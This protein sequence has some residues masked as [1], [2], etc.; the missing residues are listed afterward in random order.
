[1]SKEAC[2]RILK[3][4]GISGFVLHYGAR[5]LTKTEKQVIGRFTARFCKV[6]QNRLVF[7]NRENLDYTDNPRAFFDYLVKEGYNEKYEIIWLVSDLKKF[8]KLKYKNVKFV[9]AENKY[10]WN[11]CSAYYYTS[12]ARYFFFSHNTQDLLDYGCPGRTIINLWHGCGYKGPERG[13]TENSGKKA[14]TGFD[15]GLVPGPVFVET[16]SVAWN[17]EKEKIWPIGYPR[18]DWML[19]P[20]ITKEKMIQRLFGDWKDLE[21]KLVIWMPTFRKS[22]LKGCKEGEI[23]M[24]YQL[25]ALRGKEDLEKLDLHLRA[26][27]MYLIIK[28]HPLQTK[29]SQD[30]TKLSNIRYVTEKML[31]TAGIQLAELMGVCD[32]LISDYSSASVDFMLLHRPMA[33]VLED[34]MAYQEKRG[35]VFEDPLAYMPGEKIYDYQGVEAFLEH[36][37]KGRDLYRKERENLMPVMHNLTENYCERL[38]KQ[39]HL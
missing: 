30:E 26:L 9:T 13:L 14:R 10:G 33:F 39:L 23:K 24:L 11:S 21:N 2:K 8:R 1:M 19:H 36:V 18:Y 20:S 28:K 3:E 38:A 25:P 15:Y 22:N 37:A 4:Q 17:C 5:V 6:K 31:E 27:G 32:G 29:W 16:K 34:F 35:F 7:K 12:T